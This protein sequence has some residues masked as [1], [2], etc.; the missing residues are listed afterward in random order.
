MS[1]TEIPLAFACGSDILIGI[2][3]RPSPPP[4]L[5][6]VIVVGGP[7]YRAGSHRQHVLLARDLAAAGIAVLRFDRRGMGDS[8]GEPRPFEAIADDIAAALDALSGAIPGLRRVVLAGLCDGATAIAFFLAEDGGRRIAGA[9]LINP[10]ARSAAGLAHTQIRHHYAH[11]LL[12]AAFWRRLATGK[13]DV[14]ASARGV[15]AT[16]HAL[17]W[18]RDA[19]AH[20][21]PARPLPA[22]LSD[23]LEQT[24]VP[25]LVI[26][27]GADLTA[28]EFEDNVLAS[29]RGKAFL[30]SGRAEIH[31]IAEANHTY[32]QQAWRTQVH[33]HAIAWLT[34]P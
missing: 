15:L 33:L 5:G 10:W 12:S 6:V 20:P 17:A 21:L 23:A 11:R 14:M 27:C 32:A 3:H 1:V 30:R 24:A 16:L 8:G 25:V 28:R 19:P 4:T 22:R 26:L 7:Q 29:P 13:V 31:R 2:L 34:R 9:L 18:R